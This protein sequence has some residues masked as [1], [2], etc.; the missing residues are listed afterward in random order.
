MILRVKIGQAL[1]SNGL[2]R[3]DTFGNFREDTFELVTTNAHW[4]GNTT[5]RPKGSHPHN[6]LVPPA[7]SPLP[8]AFSQFLP[9]SLPG[10]LARPALFHANAR[11]KAH[12]YSS[13]TVHSA[14]YGAVDCS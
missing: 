12:I 14:Y 13:F 2:M 5:I 10:R 6:H 1:Y 11:S 3:T 4:P 9:T 7:H 8:P